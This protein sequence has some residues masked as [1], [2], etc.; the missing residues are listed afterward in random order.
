MLRTQVCRTVKVNEIHSRRGNTMASGQK[1]P[2][3][4]REPQTTAGAAHRWPRHPASP[5][6]GPS[7]TA[8]LCGPRPAGQ[9]RAAVRAARTMGIAGR[10]PR[11]LAGIR[12]STAQPSAR[13]QP[14]P[15]GPYRLRLG[16]GPGSSL[17]LA[18]GWGRRALSTIWGAQRSSARLLVSG[19]RTPRSRGAAVRGLPRPSLPS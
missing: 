13:P 16:E 5:H 1:R 19:T 9:A 10:K 11:S 3:P 17:P 14:E 4:S 15:W 2:G 8:Q 6:T 12:G 18:T 7:V